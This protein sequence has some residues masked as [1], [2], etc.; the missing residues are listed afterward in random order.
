MP[1][2]KKII[3][4]LITVFT[5]QIGN[6]QDDINLNIDK[7]IEITKKNDVTKGYGLIYLGNGSYKYVEKA[8]GSAP[9]RSNPPSR[10]GWEN[11]QTNAI[12]SI[13]NFTKRNN[14]S[15]KI[16]NIEKVTA[17]WNITISFN[18]FDKEGKLVLT[19]NDAK[20]K[21]LEIK[22]YLD[23]GIITLEEFNDKAASLKKILLDN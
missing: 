23:L 20:N 18:V 16:T 5:I 4:L 8:R 17:T 11:A 7:K 2:M 12:T 6:A 22:E 3:L 14:F 19:K 10:R 15:Y 9:Y 21:L 1:V 13:D